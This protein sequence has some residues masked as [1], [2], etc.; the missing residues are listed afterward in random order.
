MTF[1]STML[2]T[3]LAVAAPLHAQEPQTP[4]IT[5]TIPLRHLA[6]VDAARLISPYIRSPKGAV[7]EA[8]AARAVTVT[9]TAATLARIDSLIRENDRSPTI[10]SFR[11]QIIAADDTPSRDPAIDSLDATLRSLFRYRG[12]HLLGQGTTTAGE[13]ETFSL[14]MAGGDERYELSGEVMTVQ[15]GGAPL[16]VIDGVPQTSDKADRGSVRVRVRLGRVTSGTYQGKPIAPE[17]LL[18]TGLTVPVGQTVVL[19]S[20]APGGRNQAIILTIRP[21]VAIPPRR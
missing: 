17:S 7:Y 9:E 1:R 8:S 2:V 4:L 15:P 16:I 18:S 21:E 13:S 20:A 19:G 14:T 12:Y 3:V 6:S 5:R 11:F 10:L